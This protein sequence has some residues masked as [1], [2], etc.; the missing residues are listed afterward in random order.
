MTKIK[1]VWCTRR[2]IDKNGKTVNCA[3]LEL[4]PHA[5]NLLF[6]IRV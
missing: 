4:A 1:K 3:V 5:K 6:E 2:E